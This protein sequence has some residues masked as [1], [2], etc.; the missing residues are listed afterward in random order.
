MVRSSEVVSESAW[1]SAW[2]I[3]KMVVVLRV[4]ED[5]SLRQRIASVLDGV[6]ERVGSG[7]CLLAGVSRDGGGGSAASSG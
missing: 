3:S 4:V 1:S 7:Y 2:F 5:V 6:W